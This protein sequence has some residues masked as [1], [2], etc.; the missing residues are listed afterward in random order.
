M[1]RHRIAS[2]T[3]VIFTVFL[4]VAAGTQPLAPDFSLHDAVYAR[5][6]TYEIKESNKKGCSFTSQTRIEIMF[7]GGRSSGDNYFLIGQSGYAKIDKIEGACSGTGLKKADIVSL[8]DDRDAFLTNDRLYILHFPVTMKKGDKLWY[9]YRQGNTDIAFFPIH[10]VPNELMLEKYLVVIKH[11]AEMDIDFDFFFPRD[12]VKY[13][14]ANPSATVTTLSFDSIPKAPE[15]LYFPFNSFHAA[16]M[17]II[18]RHGDVINP[19]SP[20]DFAEWYSGFLDTI[21]R[22]TDTLPSSLKAELD[23]TT[24]NIERLRVIDDYVRGNVRYLSDVQGM[25]AIVPHAPSFVLKNLYGDCKDRAFLCQALAASYGIPVNLALV[26]NEAEPSFHGL[27]VDLFNH[28][29]CA[30]QSDSEAIFFDPTG[31][32]YSFGNTAGTLIGTAAFVI[33]S[34]RPRYEPARSFIREPSL[35]ISITGSI[36]KA[37]SCSAALILRGDYYAAA[38]GAAK[39]MDPV[40]K[41]NFLATIINSQLANIAL[42]R[43]RGTAQNDS[44]IYLSAKAD[45][46]RFVINSN[47]KK[48]VPATVFTL[49]KGDIL[50]RGGDSYPIYFGAPGNISL[51]LN[52][53]TEGYEFAPDSLAMQCGDSISYE[54][55]IH[56]SEASGAVLTYRLKVLPIIISGAIKSEFIRFCE[57]YLKTRTKMFLA[58]GVEK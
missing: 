43:F 3:F 2:L 55:G 6:V 53:M 25:N 24:G 27:H 45:L 33:D 14:I 29:I 15:L 48:Y 52:L 36:A 1:A 57:G 10:Y 13:K 41:E 35:E 30:Y 44:E 16:F 34:L 32:Y 12:S 47:N 4:N 17:T 46:G 19:V 38:A 18:R 37:E 54:T 9:G 39:N 5:T 11:P 7:P 51:T 20:A 26:S 58:R 23:T 21:P 50:E 8:T 49:L 31:K 56:R 42:E 28:V 40:N 22:L